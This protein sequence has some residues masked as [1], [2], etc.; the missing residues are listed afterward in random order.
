M[1]SDVQKIKVVVGLSG[2]VDSSVTA[3][4]LQQKNYQVEGIF[5]KNWEAD[6]DDVYCTAM[7]DLTDARSICDQLQIP[8]RKINFAKE[9][10]DNVFHYFLDEYAKGHTP[11]PDILCNK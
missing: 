7:Q 5:M 1:M 4:L 9:Y 11:N 2:G 8:F 3:L 6:D 10:W